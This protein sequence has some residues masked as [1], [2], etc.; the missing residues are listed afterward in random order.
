MPAVL[1][2]W[3][4]G[5][6]RVLAALVVTVAMAVPVALGVQVSTVSAQT[7]ATRAPVGMPVT[8]ASEAGLCRVWQEW[9]VSADR[10]E[11]VV[12]AVSA[13][14]VVVVVM[15]VPVAAVPLVAWAETRRRAPMG[16]VVMVETPVTVAQVAMAVQVT[17]SPVRRR[18]VVTAEP[19]ARRDPAVLA[20][21]V[22]AATVL[23]V[24]MAMVVT[25]VSAVMVGTRR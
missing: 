17:P 22:R 23:P 15:V 20:E 4:A 5:R 21:S 12:S 9:V 8:V 11:M 16:L 19:E 1:A 25:V 13:A 6:A 10:V 14:L 18:T 3:A 7:V 24:L 2:E